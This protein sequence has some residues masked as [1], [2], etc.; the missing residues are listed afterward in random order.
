M[1]S[2]DSFKSQFFGSNLLHNRVGFIQVH[3]NLMQTHNEVVCIHTHQVDIR[4]TLILQ[5]LDTS[6]SASQTD[7]TSAF[8]YIHAPS[9]PIHLHLESAHFA[10]MAHHPPNFTHFR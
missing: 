4:V 9:F 2:I 3:D 8:L 5:S 1:E 6:L 7:S 10:S